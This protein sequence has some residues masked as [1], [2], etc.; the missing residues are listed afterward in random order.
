[1]RPATVTGIAMCL[2][3]AAAHA[4]EHIGHG[5]F[6]DVEIYRPDGH[7]AQV[8]LWLDGERDHNEEL[9]PMARALYE[10]HAMIARVDVPALLDNLAADDAG[11][12]FPAG[13]LENLA[14]YVEGYAHLPAYYTPLLV[15]NG[16][17]ASLAYALLAQAPSGTFGG[18]LSLGFSTHLPLTKPLC[19]GDHLR[20]V[21]DDRGLRLQPSPTIGAPWIVLQGAREHLDPPDAIRT[22]VTAVADAQFETVPDVDNTFR[23]SLDWLPQYVTAYTALVSGSASPQSAPP[24]LAGLPVVENPTPVAGDA[25]AV[26]LSGDGGWAGLDKAVANELVAKGIPVVGLDSLRY[27]WSA[28]TPA[29]LAADLDRI[30]DY[31]SERWHKTRAVLV[32]YS[33]GA[34]VLPFAVNRLTERSKQLLAQVVLLAPSPKA[35]F[36][37]HASHWLGEGDDGLPALP[38][39]VRLDATKTLCVYGAD[40]DDALCPKIAPEHARAVQLPGGHHFNGA[41]ESLARLILATLQ[42]AR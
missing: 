11:C 41:Y 16:P 4:A 22:F 2:L 6:K 38:E 35:S 29:G 42:P 40:D 5:R 31:Y 9:P 12:V 36:E 19:H 14:H 28:R 34:D 3:S 24:E 1:M 25:F 8:V 23:G 17:G 13:D 33:Q 21:A 27:F 30:L 18:A 32:G 7:I 15:G 39:A 37:F 20:F 10:Q 26:M